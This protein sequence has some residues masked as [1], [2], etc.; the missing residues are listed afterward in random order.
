MNRRRRRALTLRDHPGTG[1][2]DR[3]VAGQQQRVIA[4]LG[5]EGLSE[6]PR[7]LTREAMV[8]AIFRSAG[9]MTKGWIGCMRSSRRP[10]RRRTSAFLSRSG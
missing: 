4:L 3:R 5:L 10:T 6:T 7:L 9:L 8:V 1:S 2:A